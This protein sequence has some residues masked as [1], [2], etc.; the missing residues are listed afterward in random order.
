[1][2]LL[3]I[4]GIAG[5]LVATNTATLHG[6]AVS[7]VTSSIET[8]S[9]RELVK[10]ALPAVVSVD[11]RGKVAAV[12][13]GNQPSRRSRP[14][15]QFR[16]FFEDFGNDGGFEFQFPQQQPMPRQAFGS[17]FLIDP[18]GTVLTNYHVV[19]GADR[20]T[21]TLHD[22]RVFHSTDIQGDSKN[23]LALV[24]FKTESPL[25]SLELGD[26]D[27]MEIGDR[28]LAIGAPFRLSG[29]VTAGIVS[30]KSRNGFGSSNAVY[31][32]YMQTDAAINPGNSGG[33]LVNMAGKVIGINTMIRTESGGF[34]GIGL[35]ISSNLAKSIVDQLAHGGKVHRGY[36]GVQ[37]EPLTSE[38]AEELGLKRDVTGVVVDRVFPKAPAAKA[39]VKATDIITTV[40]GKP[41]K[42]GRDLQ[43]IVGRHPLHKPVELGIVRDGKA[44]QV[45]VTI[46]E[47]PEDYGQNVLTQGRVRPKSDES[48]EVSVDKIGIN[49]ADLSPA[50]AQGF[51]YDEDAR[52]VVIT[53]VQQDGLAAENGLTRGMLIAKINKV[54]MKTASAVRNALEKADFQKGVLLQVQN[55]QGVSRFV[56]LKGETANK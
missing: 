52:G 46:E 26:S 1:L 54:E 15:E 11:A 44:L 45:Q 20:V 40:D 36:L 48:E 49:V 21:I 53:S 10:R 29:T 38:V 51:G 22:G 31:E 12:K 14:E 42:S 4:G 41:V 18:K 17:G 6:Q 16:K 25:P 24:K 8:G 23:D 39:G 3:V 28:V 5:G 34:Q 50:L 47:Q 27:A 19:A 9:Y 55:S 7:P 13:K 43:Y 32:D 37:V 33:P 2:V 35:A 30:A 56:V